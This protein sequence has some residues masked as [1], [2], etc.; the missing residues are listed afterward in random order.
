MKISHYCVKPEAHIQRKIQDQGVCHAIKDV[1]E[2]ITI[3]LLICLDP[4]ILEQ[5][6]SVE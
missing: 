2:E 6:A 4:E 5:R 1:L 3:V